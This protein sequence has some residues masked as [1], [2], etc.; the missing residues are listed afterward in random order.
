MNILAY[1]KHKL[2]EKYTVVQN[3]FKRYYSTGSN[4]YAIY[5]YKEG[6]LTENENYTE[7]FLNNRNKYLQYRSE[8]II[9]KNSYTQSNYTGCIKLQY[10]R[11]LRGDF[12]T[13]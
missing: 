5:V 6:S 8:F 11:Y 2:L 4:T 9:K 7:I 12:R 3:K 13:T 1:D 10:T